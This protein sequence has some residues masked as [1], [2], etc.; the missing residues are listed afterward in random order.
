MRGSFQVAKFFNIPV[1]VHWT[2]VLIF[3][4]VFFLGYRENW[5]WLSM[6]WSGLFVLALFVCVVLHEFGHALTARRFGVET[7]D[8]ILS[9]IGGV[10]RL[11]R[12]PEKPM[13]EFQVAIA[14]PLVNVGISLALSP[15]FLLVSG[16]TRRQLGNIFYSLVYPESNVFVRDLSPLDYFL[17]GLIALNLTLAVFNLLPAFPMDG[18][19]VLRA[20]LSL[21]LGRRRATQIAAFIGQGF[22]VILV[23]YGLWEFSL[24]TAFIGVFVFMTAASEN[25]MVRIDSSLDHHTVGELARRNFTKIYQRDPIQVAA[26]ELQRGMERNF[27]VFDEWQNLTGVLTEASIMEAMKKG[28]PDDRVSEYLNT[29]YEYVLADDPLR[30]AFSKMQWENYLIL[31]VFEEGRVTGLIDAGVLNNFLRLQQKLDR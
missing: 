7:R 25:R 11:D 24:I 13:Q 30:T 21:R 15:Y 12:L 10:A 17:F 20:L 8:I 3:A 28:Q 14:G 6:G 29:H 18:G 16:E 9:P 31:P 23:A 5:D 19:R 22:A 4:Y 26:G 2:F 27:L 1:Q